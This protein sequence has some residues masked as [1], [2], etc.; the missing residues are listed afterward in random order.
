MKNAETALNNLRPTGAININNGQANDSYALH[1]DDWYRIQTLTAQGRLLPTT[2]QALLAQLKMHF[3]IHANNADSADAEADNKDDKPDREQ[4]HSI[5]DVDKLINTQGG[6]NTETKITTL[7]D[8]YASIKALCHDWDQDKGEGQHRQLSIKTELVNT[9]NDVVSFEQSFQTYFNKL[10]DYLADMEDEEF[11]SGKASEKARKKFIGVVDTLTKKAQTHYTT[12]DKAASRLSTF[13]RAINSEKQTLSSTISDIDNIANRQKNVHKEKTDK[14]EALRAELAD[15]EKRHRDATIAASTSTATFAV[16][17]V[18]FLIGGMNLIYASV[19]QAAVGASFA[20][21][22]LEDIKRIQRDIVQYTNELQGADRFWALMSFSNNH[23]NHVHMAAKDV[24][25]AL[26]NI[27]T[28]W[29]EMTSH[30]QALKN[31]VDDD[32]RNSAIA[33]KGGALTTA[34]MQWSAARAAADHFRATAFID[35]YELEATN[36]EDAEKE[37]SQKAA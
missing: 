11:F 10:D 34:Q 3:P 35:T 9:A 12:A 31:T 16:G 22:A 15:A 6:A 19:I 4:L 26:N 21:K 32:L 2:A 27:R 29:T 30:L 23:A 28:C 24:L 37:I 17:V 5:S 13:I 1:T 20:I 36:L 33:L 14:L 25:T 8:T 7:L 18:T